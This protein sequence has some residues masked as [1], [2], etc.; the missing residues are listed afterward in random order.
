MPGHKG[1]LGFLPPDVLKYDVTELAGT[2]NLYMPSGVICQSQKL[3]APSYSARSCFYLV[4]GSSI[5]VMASLLSVAG[6]GEKVIFARDFHLSAASGII[7]SGI[8]PVFC[9]PSAKNTYLPGVVSLQDVK[10]VISENEDAQAVYL[11][12]P[13]Y[14][15]LC[16]DLNEIAALA[17]SV[18]MF[19]VVDGAHAAAFAYNDMLPAHPGEA[20]ADLWT[21]SLHKTL[22]VPGQCSVL[23]VGEQSGLEDDLVK[24]NINLLQTTSPSYLL[25]AS[26]DH[27]LAEMREGGAKLVGDAILLV[28]EFILRIEML[29][30]YKCVTAD[31]PKGTGAVDRDITKLVIDVTDRG[32]TGFLAEQKLRRSGIYVEGADHRNII[33]L[34]SFGNTRRDYEQLLTA[35]D[36]ISGTNYHISNEMNTMHF[37]SREQLQYNMRNIML[38]RTVNLP[39]LKAVGRTAACTVG[40]Y[41]PGVPYILPGQQ[42][43]VETLE[44]L[45]RLQ[46]QGYSLF[47]TDGYTLDVADI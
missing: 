15:G 21:M 5:G 43:D 29:G 26:I 17:H 14:Y 22:H 44:H 34:C 10:K 37:K 3:N 12:Y 28:E 2:D 38:R 27:A 32:M 16:P 39:F 30:G 35:L 7:L 41:P 36:E 19:V 42:I 25:L 8:K 20:G 18:G 6:P 13:N 11:T 46:N 40:S 9:Y 4:N 31:I 1:R 45:V 33:L 47:G 23:C 24:R